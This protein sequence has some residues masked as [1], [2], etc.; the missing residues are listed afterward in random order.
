MKKPKVKQKVNEDRKLRGRLIRGVKEN[1]NCANRIR[2]KKNTLFLEIWQLPVFWSRALEKSC[3]IS[4]M[5]SI[6]IEFIITTNIF[7]VY[8]LCIGVFTYTFA[9]I[10]HVHFQKIPEEDI[11]TPGIGVTIGC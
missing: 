11:R 8:I 5:S 6:R 3:R 9:S 2:R 1:L 4:S 7:K 10:A